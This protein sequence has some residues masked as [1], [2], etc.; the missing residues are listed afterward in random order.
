[1]VACRTQPSPEF[2]PPSYEWRAEYNI[3]D[4]IR[5][6]ILK[7]NIGQTSV[8]G[9]M[10]Q[11]NKVGAVIFIFVLRS[12]ILRMNNERSGNGIITN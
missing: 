9:R 2:H 5:G 12:R 1:M 4:I 6:R 11:K 3:R 10:G 7:M 8:K